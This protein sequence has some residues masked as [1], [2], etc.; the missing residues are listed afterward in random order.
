[1][2]IVLS[3]IVFLMLFSTKYSIYHPDYIS[4][5]RCNA[6]KGIFICLVFIRHIRSYITGAVD[7]QFHV[8]DRITLFIDGNLGQL[9]V[10]MFLFYSGFGLMESLKKKGVA[11]VHNIP[12]KRLLPTLLNFDVAVIVFCLVD[13]LLGRALSVKSILLSFVAWE[14]VGNSNWYIFVILCCY[15]LFYI[16]H[17]VIKKENISVL[18]L[19]LS[20]C[21]LGFMLA[22]LKPEWWYN[23]LF[24]FVFGC[25][26][27]WKII[28]REDVIIKH[29]LCILFLTIVFFVGLFILPGDFYCIK[30]NLLSV[31][32]S[33]LVVLL[34][35]KFQVQSVFLD[36]MGMNLFPLYIYQR[37]PMIVLSELGIGVINQ[38]SELFTLTAF[39]ITL[40]LSYLFKFINVSRFLEKKSVHV[41]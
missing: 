13:L 36:W 10:A 26:Y 8:L 4:A 5:Q 34:T 23:T 9:I 31:S 28:G 16:I 32:F 12:Q 38:Y 14:S 17:L 3:L 27:S 22:H 18:V 37:L 6:I 11:Y 2:W 1:M 24:C 41:K 33:F 7:G 25:F 40:G 29:Y 19:L 21:L 39:V 20:L 30:Y 15:L 35:M